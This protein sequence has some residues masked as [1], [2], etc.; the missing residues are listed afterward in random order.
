[1]HLGAQLARAQVIPRRKNVSIARLISSIQQ[2]DLHP[3]LTAETL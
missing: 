1:M 3:Q 2:R